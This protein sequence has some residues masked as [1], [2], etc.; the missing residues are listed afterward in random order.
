MIWGIDKLGRRLG[1]IIGSAGAAVALFYI[2]GYTT[3]TRSFDGVETGSGKTAGGYA[4][5]AMIYIFSVFYAMSWNGI[6]WIFWYVQP[7]LALLDTN[8]FKCRGVPYGH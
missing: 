1:L 2:G 5:I 6:P 4:A 8:E 7:A 3:A